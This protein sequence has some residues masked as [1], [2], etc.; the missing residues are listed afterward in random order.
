MKDTE[1]KKL[2]KKLAK[3]E[4]MVGGYDDKVVNEVVYEDEYSPEDRR[5]IQARAAKQAEQRTID[6]VASS[7]IAKQDQAYRDLVEL[8]Q[9]MKDKIREVANMNTMGN[10]QL[11]LGEAWYQGQGIDKEF[12]DDH[13]ICP[14]CA[15]KIPV[16]KIKKRLFKRKSRR[17]VAKGKAPPMP[18]KFMRSKSGIKRKPGPKKGG[19]RSGKQSD[20]MKFCKAVAKTPKMEGKPWNEVMKKASSLRKK[21][22]TIEQLKIA[23]NK[24]Q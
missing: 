15:G 13:L 23:K 22:V 2:K 11:G 1:V 5:V 4:K 17:N 12:D 24:T 7:S 16:R 19:A 3:L 14:H 18:P 10:V 9:E 20:W 6:E 21:G 8:S